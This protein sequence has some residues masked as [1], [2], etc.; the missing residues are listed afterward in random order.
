MKSLKI[1]NYVLYGLI[2]IS[3]VILLLFM[4]VGFDNVY[5]ENPKYNDP[6]MT[7]LLLVWMYVLVAV[8]AILSVVSVVMSIKNNNGS[9]VK[10]VAG[11]TGIIA[12]AALIISLVLGGIVGA[13]DHEDLIINN[14]AFE[15]AQHGLDYMLTNV[16]IVSAGLLGLV[17]VV[18]TVVSMFMQSKK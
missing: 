4:F 5:E 2:G 6:K 8:T 10:G 13:A 12:V 16:S 9:D 17:A 14:K 15:H 1:S 3:V 18:V 11:K 7:D